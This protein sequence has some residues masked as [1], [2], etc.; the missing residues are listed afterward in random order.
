M[1]DKKICEK[2]SLKNKCKISKK[3]YSFSVTIPKEIH[4]KQLNFQ[5]EEYFKNRYRQR[6]KIEGKNAE[7]KRYHGLK[8][9]W[10]KGIFAMNVQS[11]FTAFVLNVKRI[12][13][14][15]TLNQ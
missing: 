8:Q 5:K 7:A 13:K 14:L 2:C 15:E 10:S 3:T 1:F 12:I 6:Y 11:Y 9:A 4:Q